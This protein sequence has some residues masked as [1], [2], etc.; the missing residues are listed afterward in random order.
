[1]KIFESDSNHILVL[2]RGKELLSALER[3]A[4]QRSLESAWVSGLGA[5]SSAMVAW[6][7][8][9]TKQYI[10]RAFDEPLEILSLTGNLSQV[11]GKPFWHLHGTFAGRD[12]NAVGG[13]IKQLVVGVTCELHLSPLSI[14]MTRRF[15][16][17]TGLN[18]LAL[19]AC[20][21]S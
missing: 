6:Y 9:E 19:P 17:T 12:Y 4:S 7:D 21:D 18:L 11:D 15:D 16:D 13:H 14:A 10:D 3:Y 5:A 1:M 20:S 8:I 2:E